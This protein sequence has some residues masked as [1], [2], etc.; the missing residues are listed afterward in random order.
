M[1]TGDRSKNARLKD[2]A[3]ARGVGEGGELR[4]TGAGDAETVW[5]HAMGRGGVQ[6][7]GLGQTAPEQMHTSA[8][9]LHHAF[10]ALVATRSAP[11][12]CAAVPMAPGPRTG[13]P[14]GALTLPDPLAPG[15]VL[16]RVL[17]LSPNYRL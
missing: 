3:P 17:S 10:T 15:R 11:S 12:D 2:V 1:H 16:R 13:K 9:S 8:T 7:T 14:A 6:G 4:R 5:S